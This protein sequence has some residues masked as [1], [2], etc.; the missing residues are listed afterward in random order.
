MN[1][2]PWC[3]ERRAH[4][5]ELWRRRVGL[6]EGWQ[7][8]KSVV[9]SL[10]LPLSCK[11]HSNQVAALSSRWGLGLPHFVSLSNKMMPWCV[12][13]I[14]TPFL[15]QLLIKMIRPISLSAKDL[16]NEPELTNVAILDQHH[17]SGIYTKLKMHSWLS[18][19]NRFYPI[20]VKRLIFCFWL[21]LFQPVLHTK[22]KDF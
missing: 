1:F 21:L 20:F 8:T 2:L 12:M 11:T 22:C 7:S 19:K 5:R 6:L 9:L 14:L 13:L 10:P 3:S 4:D 15:F 17:H 18:F 16:L